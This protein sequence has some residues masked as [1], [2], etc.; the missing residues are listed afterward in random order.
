MEGAYTLFNELRLLESRRIGSRAGRAAGTSLAS[1]IRAPRARE[2]TMSRMAT[3]WRLRVYRIMGCCL[4]HIFR[5]R[6]VSDL[7]RAAREIGST[8]QSYS[9]GL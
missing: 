1:Q 5:P 6:L 3:P 4:A 2:R 9:M 8:D 7:D